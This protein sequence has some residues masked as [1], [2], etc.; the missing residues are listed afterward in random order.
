MPN[1]LWQLS[2]SSNALSTGSD[3]ESPIPASTSPAPTSPVVRRSS[4]TR[5]AA[6]MYSPQGKSKSKAAAIILFHILFICVEHMELLHF[7]YT[8]IHTVCNTLYL[9]QTMSFHALP[10]VLIY[11]K[12]LLNV[13]CWLKVVKKLKRPCLQDQMMSLPS[14][15]RHLLRLHLQL[16]AGQQGPGR[17]LRFSLLLRLKSSLRVMHDLICLSLWFYLC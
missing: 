14:L 6:V 4:R 11:S 16:C 2:K 3:D 13:D 7:L 17:L 8:W 5:K 9:Y 12:P 1:H 15:P 10:F